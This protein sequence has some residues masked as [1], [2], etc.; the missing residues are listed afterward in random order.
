MLAVT[1]QEEGGGDAR[2]EGMFNNGSGVGVVVPVHEVAEEEEDKEE[3]KVGEFNRIVDG[4]NN[5]E[6]NGQL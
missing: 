1:D 3:D 6:D 4:I 2:R 5:N